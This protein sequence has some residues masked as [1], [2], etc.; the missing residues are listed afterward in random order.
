MSV[1]ATAVPGVVVRVQRPD[2]IVPGREEHCRSARVDEPDPTE[3]RRPVTLGSEQDAAADDRDRAEYQRQPQRLVEDDQRDRDS[4]ERRGADH[5]RRARS[6]DLAHREREQD[7]RAARREQAGEQERPGAVEIRVRTPPRRARR[8]APTTMVASAAPLASGSPRSAMRRS[9]PSSRRRAPPTS[10]ASTTAVMPIPRTSRASVPAAAGSARTIPAMITA[11]PSQPTAP[12]RSPASV[13]PKNAAHTG[14]SENT[15][16]VRVA[17]VAP[18]GPGL[19]EERERARED[20]GH[21]QRAPDRPAVR[22]LELPGSDSDDEQ[23]GERDEHLDER[24]R[25]RVVPWGVPLH[26]HDLQRVDAPRRP[27]TSSSPAGLLPWTPASIARPTRGERDADPRRARRCACGRARARAAA[28]ARRT[29][30]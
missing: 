8:R 14:S 26:Q 30:R 23:T 16:A 15:S 19:D 4:D 24:E 22:Q 7:L 5:H 27:S 3:V 2:E 17:L 11:Q 9:R 12:S 25:E 6:A 28:S 10:S 20:A 21:E 13:K 1:A 29:S 18:L